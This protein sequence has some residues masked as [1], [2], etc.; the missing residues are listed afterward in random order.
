MVPQHTPCS[1]SAES[2]SDAIAHAAPRGFLPQL[3]I[4]HAVPP[5]Q[6]V[7][8]VQAPRQSPAGPHAYGAHD[9]DPSGAQMPL[10]T[11]YRIYF[12]EPM[13]FEGDP[14]DDDAVIEEQVATVQ[15]AIQSMLNRG[16]KERKS[17]FW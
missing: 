9:R 13:V 8:F 12:G 11:K 4:E 3:P 6:S 5:A 14:D 17:I 15:G 10:P 16:L 2:Q 7:A 1:Q